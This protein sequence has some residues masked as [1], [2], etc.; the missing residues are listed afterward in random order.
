M[1]YIIPGLIIAVVIFL[2][3]ILIRTVPKS[4]I[5]PLRRLWNLTGKPP[6]RPWQ[7]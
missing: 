1:E 3:V 7:N 6:L 5:P 4:K 2:A